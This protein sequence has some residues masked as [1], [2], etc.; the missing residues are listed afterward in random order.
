MKYKATKKFKELGIER[1]YHRLEVEQFHALKRD[2]AVEVTLNN[3]NQYLIDDDYI[4]EVKQEIYS[5][6]KKVKGE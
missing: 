6:P 2:E 1:N 4:E 5:K 3:R